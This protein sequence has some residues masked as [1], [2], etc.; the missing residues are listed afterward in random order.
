MT[1]KIFY[2]CETPDMKLSIL[3]PSLTTRY[4]SRTALLSSL[5][6]QYKGDDVEVLTQ[7]DRGYMSIGHKRNLLLDRAK[8]D[9]LCFA[10]DDD[11]LVSNYISLIMEGIDKGVDCCSLLGV[12]TTNGT[13]PELFE[14]SIKHKEWIDGTPTQGIRY[15]RPPNHL[16][17]IKSDIAKK[18]RFEEINHGEDRLWSDAIQR[19]G[20]LK[21]EHMITDILYHYKFKTVK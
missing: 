17:C 10:D 2:L 11:E 20:L 16:N 15:F 12:Y 13:N 18:F 14:H 3:I 1:K 21:T 4:E 8:G 5:S 9:Y 7:V 6:T 19:S